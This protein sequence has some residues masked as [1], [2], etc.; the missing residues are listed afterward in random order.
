MFLPDLQFEFLVLERVA[1]QE[2]NSWIPC[3]RKLERGKTSQELSNANGLFHWS[4]YGTKIGL[5]KY[6]FCFV[7]RY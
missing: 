6:L 4:V 3:V 1:F 7:E 2:G 5:K